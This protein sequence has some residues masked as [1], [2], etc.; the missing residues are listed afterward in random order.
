MQYPMLFQNIYPTVPDQ[1]PLNFGDVRFLFAVSRKTSNF[2]K[3]YN[4]HYVEMFLFYFQF[5][6][7]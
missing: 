5:L 6:L 4:E 3:Q 7:N 1:N 2:S